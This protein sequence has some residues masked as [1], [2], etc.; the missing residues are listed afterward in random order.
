[1]PQSLAADLEPQARLYASEE[2]A[3]GR[4]QY[5]W[6]ST[7]GARTH[8]HFDSDHNLFVQLLGAKRFVLWVR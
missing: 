8:T 1:M 7:P 4:M 3:E 2:D 6:V 5:L